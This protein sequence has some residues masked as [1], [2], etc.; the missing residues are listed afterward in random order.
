MITPINT[1][2]PEW[3]KDPG[4]GKINLIVSLSTGSYGPFKPYVFTATDSTLKTFTG[5]VVLSGVPGD[6]LGY[7]DTFPIYAK[8][9]I[10]FEACSPNSLTQFHLTVVLITF[11]PNTSQMEPSISSMQLLHRSQDHTRM[12]RLATSLAGDTQKVQALQRS[13]TEPIVCM[14]QAS[15][16]KASILTVA[17]LQVCGW[18]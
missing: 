13:L 12:S 15:P 3:F 14:T 8:Y 5:P 9:V 2:A 18:L 6:G 17:H 1:W 16:F 7:I 10:F 4:T 11:S